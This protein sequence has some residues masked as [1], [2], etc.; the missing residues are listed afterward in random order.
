MM[1][2]YEVQIVRGGVWCR[3]GVYLY[4]AL[5]QRVMFRRRQEGQEAR[6]QALTVD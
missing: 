4:E 1:T 2:I 6:V 5:A 3:W